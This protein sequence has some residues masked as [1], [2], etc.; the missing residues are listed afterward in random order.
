MY[1]E[2]FVCQINHGQMQCEIFHVLLWLLV[3]SGLA[4]KC[5]SWVS[6]GKVISHFL[7]FAIQQDTGA[8]FTLLSCTSVTLV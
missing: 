3:Q 6:E 5:E 2:L 8:G 4:R 1:R 7:T